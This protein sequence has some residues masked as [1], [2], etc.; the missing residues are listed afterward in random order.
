MRDLVREFPK[1]SKNTEAKHRRRNGQ[2]SWSSVPWPH[3]WTEGMV[4]RKAETKMTGGMGMDYG[5]D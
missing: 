5:G 3:Y 1:E 4:W 2:T